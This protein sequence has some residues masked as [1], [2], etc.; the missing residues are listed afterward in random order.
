MLGIHLISGQIAY[1]ESNYE[2]FYK[3]MD[4]NLNFIRFIR[5]EGGGGRRI[6]C[7][8]DKQSIEMVD[9]VEE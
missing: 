6:S 4:D 8:I 5:V 2:E 1:V 7:I 9:I 3:K